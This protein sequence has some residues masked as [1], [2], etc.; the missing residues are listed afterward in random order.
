M[1]I[2]Q[3]WA[4]IVI[5]IVIAIAYVWTYIAQ[6]NAI[7]AKNETIKSLESQISVAKSLTEIQ[8]ANFQTYREML[9]LTDIQQHINIQVSIQ[10]SEAVDKVISETG[11]ALAKDSKILD[12]AVELLSKDT[13]MFGFRGLGFVLYIL[14]RNNINDDGIKWTAK[15]FYPENPYVETILLE[16]MTKFRAEHPNG[17]SEPEKQIDRKKD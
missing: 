17:I 15:T 7:N 11:V 12:R 14:K 6:R 8:S 4:D 16:E 9:K 1:E 10:L 13:M 5:M 3:S 2:F